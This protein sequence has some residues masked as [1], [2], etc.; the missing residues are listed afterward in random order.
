V[1]NESRLNGRDRYQK[2]CDYQYSRNSFAAGPNLATR[3][4][5]LPLDFDCPLE[6]ELTIR[7]FPS[8]HPSMNQAQTN[9]RRRA[10][11]QQREMCYDCLRPVADC[12]CAWVREI[13][14]R[15]NILILQHRRERFH[16]FNTARMV[17]RSLVNSQLVVG[18]TEEL[19]KKSLPIRES[20]GLLYPLSDARNLQELLPEERPDQL[21]VLDGTWHQSKALLRQIPALHGLPRFK[22]APDQPG[23]FRIRYEPTPISLSTVEAVV[24]AL[25]LL[26]PQTLGFDRLLACFQKMVD[27]QLSHPHAVYDGLPLHLR[28]PDNDNT[29]SSIRNRLKDIVVACGENSPSHSRRPSS[30][31]DRPIVWF[32]ERLRDGQT[33]AALLHPPEPLSD[34]ILQH[35]EL[36][37]NEWN[38]AMTLAMFRHQWL[39]F[40]SVDDL[41]VVP[42]S[43]HL[44]L[45]EAIGPIARSVSLKSINHPILKSG[46]WIDGELPDHVRADARVKLPGRAGK[47]LAVCGAVVRYL[48]RDGTESRIAGQ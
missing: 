45:L 30:A 5:R 1:H 20:A 13:D 12:Y 18:R 46:L 14:N 19:A 44:K 34:R 47:R 8:L 11:Q 32:A 24:E 25:R 36:S 16:A 27:H 29:P 38:D 6:I 26:E 3:L 10:L 42:S 35:L 40:V 48:R 33:F 23:R 41:I 22:L 28:N 17:H 31:A 37:R 43:R 4:D 21:V 9:R 7:L 39:K 15:T 2:T